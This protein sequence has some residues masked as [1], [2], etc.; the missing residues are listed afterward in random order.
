M[1][2]PARRVQPS[3]RPH[4]LFCIKNYLKYPQFEPLEGNL[5]KTEHFYVF[6]GILKLLHPFCQ[7]LIYLKYRKPQSLEIIQ[8]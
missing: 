2:L 5:R 6:I 3:A 8:C 7:R 4:L 1:P